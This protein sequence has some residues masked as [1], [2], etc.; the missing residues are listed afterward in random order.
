MLTLASKKAAQTASTLTFASYLSFVPIGIATVLLG[1]LLPVLS[2]RWSLNYSQA[3][4]LFTAQYVA[5]TCAVALS[6]AVVRLRGYRFTII[7]G[8]LLIAAALALLLRGSPLLGIVCIMAYGAGLGV[9]VPAG[10]L[11]VAEINPER[12]GAAL[13]WLNFCWSAGA[14]ACPFL[15]GVA[16]R[17]QRTSLF[18][19]LIASLSLAM[20]TGIALMSA[21]IAEPSAATSPQSESI[22]LIRNRPI[23]FLVI[24]ALF[25]LYVGT[26]N[27]FG[28]W[29][30]S[31]AKALGTS[32]P[33]LALMTPSYFY[34]TLMLGRLLAP[35]L[36]N[37]F[38]E[39]AISRVGL[40]LACAGTGGLLFSHGLTGITVSAC[41]SGL[42]L[43]SV[44]PIT[45]SLLGREFG[46]SSSRLGSFMFVLSNI[47]GGLLP[48]IVGV[49]ATRFGTLKAGL[50]VPVFGCA[51]MLALFLRRWTPVMKSE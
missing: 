32:N 22:S 18:L 41:A 51:A 28:G 42:G 40:L 44:Y 24:A 25:F 50:V 21:G 16:V 20:A 49:A 3:G 10:N 1:P 26:E 33:S 15:V 4:A 9:A 5:S 39:I 2:A 35:F 8:L 19:V 14:V 48:W 29:V 31:Y 17:T 11:L 45:I 43:S 27:G 36:L 7:T 6:G 34:S 30:A 23:T 37:L 38:D 47:G 13:S 12:R 46:S